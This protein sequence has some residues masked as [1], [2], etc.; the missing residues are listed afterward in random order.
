MLQYTLGFACCERRADSHK[1]FAV[2]FPKSPDGVELLPCRRGFLYPVLC[3][4][5]E[6]VFV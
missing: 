1:H 4:P 5:Q 6:S 3:P 2:T